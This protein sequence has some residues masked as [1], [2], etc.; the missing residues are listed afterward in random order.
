MSD[1][2][3]NKPFGIGNGINEFN[4]QAEEAKAARKSARGTADAGAV[5]A[6]DSPVSDTNA[7]EAIEAIGRMRSADKLKH[8]I[9]NDKRVSVK[10]AAR[11]RLDELTA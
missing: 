1:F 4:A 9:D 8:V 2:D 6:D 10:E 5:E 3:L 7:D 11:K